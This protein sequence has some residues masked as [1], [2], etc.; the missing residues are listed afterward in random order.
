MAAQVSGISIA[1]CVKVFT[2]MEEGGLVMLESKAISVTMT[3]FCLTD[4]VT[5][6]TCQACINSWNFMM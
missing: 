4:G 3:L 6:P 1:S 5:Q 2:M